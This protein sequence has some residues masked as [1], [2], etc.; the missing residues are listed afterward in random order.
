MEQKNIKP[1]MFETIKQPNKIY[2]VILIIELWERFGYYGVQAII[3]L[4]FVKQL[5]YTEAESFYIFGAFGALVY[6]FIWIGGWLGD[7]YLGAKQTLV[8]G[9]ITLML[10]Y[11]GLALANYHTVFYALAGIVVGNALFK[12]NIG[13][14]ISKLY[15][16]TSNKLDKAI[17]YLYMTNNIGSMFSMAITPVFAEKGHWRIAFCLSAIGL[18]LG[19][20]NY[21]VHRY[22]LQVFKPL[23]KENSTNVKRITLVMTASIVAGYVIAQLLM[24]TNI[25]NMIVYSIAGFVF[26]YFFKIAFSLQ[27]ILKARMLVAA[28]LIL[29]AV[30]FF[31]LYNQTP[32]SLIFFAAHNINNTFFDWKI[33]PAEYQVLNSIAIILMSPI[34]AWMH[35]QY[36]MTHV[37]KFCIGMTLCAAS[38]LVLV[39]PNYT[40]TNGLASPAWMVLTYFLQGAGELLISGLGL[41]M[42]AE[43]CPPNM[44]GFMIGIWYLTIMIAGPIGAWV[45]AMTILPVGT[46]DLTNTL[47]MEIYTNVFLKIGLVTGFFASIMWLSRPLLNRLIQD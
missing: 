22:L 27:G 44:N 29:Q 34:L 12:A 14:L 15:A 25:C 35:T 43:L 17:T 28:V 4:Y 39:I 20:S 1:N 32:T 33:P 47:S 45:G 30:L 37:T 26:L 41:A 13:S 11:L 36:R 46:A 3:T 2:L 5:G 40:S 16:K 38:F 19:L 23:A 18:F 8:L 9:A 31:I 10:S 24:H 7:Q 21:F 6:G 42:V